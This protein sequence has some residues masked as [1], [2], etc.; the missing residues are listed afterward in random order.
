[1]IPTPPVISIHKVSVYGTIDLIAANFPYS[2]LLWTRRMS[3]VGDF[4]CA[5][6]GPFPAPWP[7]RYI[8][9]ASGRPEV[10]IV[11]KIEVDEDGGTAPATVSGRFLESLWDRWRVTPSSLPATGGSWRQAVTAACRS[12]HCSDAPLIRPGAGTDVGRGESYKITDDYGKSGMELIYSETAAHGARPMLSYN[13]AKSGDVELRIV[14]GVD[15]TRTQDSVPPCIFSLALASVS[16]IS[17]AED[18][19]AAASVVMAYCEAQ[20]GTV[21][22]QPAYVP[23]FDPASGWES[24][25]VEDVGSLLSLPDGVEPTPEQVAQAGGLRAYDH[26]PVVSIDFDCTRVGYM[27][28]WDLCDLV[29]VEV[30]S[31]G[32]VAVQRIEEVRESYDSDGPKLEVTAGTKQMSRLA[33]AM[34]GRR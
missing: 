19:S 3:T 17:F 21:V 29:E 10:G 2:S 28:E 5:L 24:V 7:G 9:T 22:E 4:E 18:V 33:R 31:L 1:M 11:E 6:L 32:L 34:L 14:D 27:D 25:A 13:R 8:V 30:P 16:S 15:R 12:W 20:D 23:G 26:M